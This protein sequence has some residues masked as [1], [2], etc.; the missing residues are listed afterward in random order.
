MRPPVGMTLSWSV[1]LLVKSITSKLYRATREGFEGPLGPSWVV[2]NA[3]Q[4]ITHFP[5]KTSHG[6]QWQGGGKATAQGNNCIKMSVGPVAALPTAFIVF[7]VRVAAPL[8]STQGFN[9]TGREGR[10]R[11]AEGTRVWPFL[12]DGDELSS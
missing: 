3:R 9:R 2:R 5:Y 8:T 1:Y 6:E 4:V 10:P 11:S 12:W 7:G